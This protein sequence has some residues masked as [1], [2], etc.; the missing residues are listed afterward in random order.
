MYV[1]M[2]CLE[3]EACTVFS[4]AIEHSSVMRTSSF[5]F[6]SLLIQFNLER[7]L[8]ALSEAHDDIYNFEKGLGSRFDS[9]NQIDVESLDFGLYSRG[10]NAVTADLAYM[11]W[12]CNNTNK[13]LTFLDDVAEKYAH[14]AAVNGIP[15]ADFENVRVIMLET[16]AH[17]RSWNDGLK[18]KADYLSKRAQALV[19]T[20]GIARPVLMV[21]ILKRCQVYSGI[22]QRDAA[23]SHNAAVASA[24]DSAVMRV[25]AA[26]TILFLPATTTAV[27]YLETLKSH[28]DQ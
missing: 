28:S 15:E 17:L 19:Q 18:D 9:P 6:P 1:F 5:L 8:K 24:Q 14:L 2:Q 7:R 3:D 25:I 21:Y 4:T 12:S 16:H 27:G 26:I 10:L 13:Q 20:V 23:L 11:T 22:A